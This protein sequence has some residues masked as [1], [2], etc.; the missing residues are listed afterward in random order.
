M[1]RQPSDLHNYPMAA[2][3]KFVYPEILNHFC[4]IFAKLLT[5][6]EV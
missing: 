2:M 6:F 4:R 5:K 3:L 1:I